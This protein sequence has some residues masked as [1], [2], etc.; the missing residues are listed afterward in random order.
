MVNI[1]IK[2]YWNSQ[3]VKLPQKPFYFLCPY[4]TEGDAALIFI[5]TI[6]GFLVSAIVT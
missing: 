5:F 6:L 1:N 2:Y 3:M 4:W